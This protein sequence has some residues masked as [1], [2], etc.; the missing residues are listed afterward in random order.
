MLSTKRVRKRNALGAAV[1][2]V[3]MVAVV[4]V[5]AGVAIAAAV[6]VAGV[7]IAETAV[8]AGNSF[9]VGIIGQ[10][11]SAKGSPLMLRGN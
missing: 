4:A 1:G 9:Y 3:A 6:A 10:R 7:V 11:E 8:T 2:V 5:A